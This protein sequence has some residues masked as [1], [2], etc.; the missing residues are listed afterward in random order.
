MGQ[1]RVIH[2]N[3]GTHSIHFYILLFS[4]QKFSPHHPSKG[5]SKL[6]NHHHN[7]NKRKKFLFGS[8]WVPGLLRSPLG[9][10]ELSL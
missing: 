8:V 2:I 6:T 9:G 1:G 10:I 3:I 5:N 4:S 7:A